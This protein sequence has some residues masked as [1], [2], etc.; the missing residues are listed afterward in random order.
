MQRNQVTAHMVDALYQIHTGLGPGLL[1]TVYE[2]VLA[3]E[4]RKRGLRV[5]PRIWVG[6]ELWFG[7]H[8]GRHHTHRQRAF[9]TAEPNGRSRISILAQSRGARGET[10]N[11]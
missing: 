11:R 3:H 7:A 10:E 8:E 4:R 1:E 5:R 9:G 6:S 2:V